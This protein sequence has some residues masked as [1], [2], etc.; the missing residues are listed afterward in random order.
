MNHKAKLDQLERRLAHTNSAALRIRFKDGTE[1]I[2]S[3]GNAIP[4]F[5]SGEAVKAE[6]VR[7]QNGFLCDL[8]NALND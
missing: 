2:T 1:K 4:Y 6:P 5:K 7:G 8:L 3:A